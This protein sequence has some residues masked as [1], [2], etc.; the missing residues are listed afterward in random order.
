MPVSSI[1]HIDRP[2]R[3][4]D[5]LQDLLPAAAVLAFAFPVIAFKLDRGVS[6][7]SV[8]GYAAVAAAGVAIGLRR[9]S[10]AIALVVVAVAR[11]V[12]TIDTGNEFALA[13]ALAIAMYAVG[14]RGDRRTAAL[15]AGVMAVVTAIP[16]AIMDDDPFFPEMIRESATFLFPAVIGDAVRARSERLNELIETEAETRAQAERLRIARDLHDVVA[17]GLSTIAVQSG[18]AAHLIEKDPAEARASLEIIN[19]TGKATL[20]ELRGMVGVLRSSDDAPLRPAPTAPDAFADLLAGAEASGLKVVDRSSGQFP[21][22]VGDGI[23]VAVHR[24]VQEALTNVVRHAGPVT[25]VV[26]VSRGERSVTITVQNEPGT[27]DP[28]TDRGIGNTTMASTGVGLVG[29]RERAESL[30]GTC[31]T[32]PTGDGGFLVSAEIPYRELGS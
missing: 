6:E 5:W 1:G 27:G 3:A 14:R 20:E 28:I 21:P 9:W 25:T 17:H 26:E 32:G 18:V 12:V 11:V 4:V 23:I 22:S 8:A 13:P 24:I 29:M 7:A 19:Q 15:V 10:P 30:G 2:R 16:I 31:T